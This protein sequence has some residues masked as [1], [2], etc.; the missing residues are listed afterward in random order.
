M[1]SS[2]WYDEEVA[3][4]QRDDVLADQDAETAA[5]DEEDFG[6]LFVQVRGSAFLARLE[7]RPVAGQLAVGVRYVG[8]ERHAAGGQDLG[9][10]RT[11]QDGLHVGSF[12][13]HVGY[14]TSRINSWVKD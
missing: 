6:R 2:R 4:A 5:E 7:D 3:L 14:L 8:E 11:D 1:R 9:I 10:D 13:G 12:S